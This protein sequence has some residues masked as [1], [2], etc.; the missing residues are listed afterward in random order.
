MMARPPSLIPFRSR[1]LKPAVRAVTDWKREPHSR[2]PAGRAANSK[3]K[4][5]TAGRRRSRPEV[6][7]TTL[8]CILQRRTRRPLSRRS[9]QVMKP[10]PPMTI[11]AMTGRTTAGSAA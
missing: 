6:T 7:S 5:Y 9:I 1:V 11:S 4:K 8:L 2:S 3:K 10:I